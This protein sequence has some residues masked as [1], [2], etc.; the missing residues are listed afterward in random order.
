M[1]VLYFISFRIFVAKAAVKYEDVLYDEE[2]DS[3]MLVLH[4]SNVVLCCS[5]Q[6]WKLSYN[7]YW[8]CMVYVAVRV[9]WQQDTRLYC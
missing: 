8:C 6:T 4:W 1:F 9:S 3:V 2:R 7:N 5:L